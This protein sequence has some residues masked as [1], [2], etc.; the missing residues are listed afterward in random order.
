MTTSSR[1]TAA[2]SPILGW[3][4][5]SSPW[6]SSSGGTSS[7]R[8]PNHEGLFKKYFDWFGPGLEAE[9][10]RYRDEAIR[11]HGTLRLSG[12]KTKLRVP[13]DLVELYVA[14]QA[15][16]DLR[17]HG[18]AGFADSRDVKE[19]LEREGLGREGPLMEAFRLAAGVGRRG[20]VILGEPG[21]GKTT[22]LKRLLLRC[23]QE[24]PESLGLPP[25][26]VPVLLPLRGLEDPDKETVDSFIERH[27]NA[28]IGLSSDFGRRLL[29]RGTLLLLFDGLDEVANP[30]RREKV[31]RWV[32][33]VLSAHPSCS[34]VV[35]C[36]F[37]GYGEQGHGRAEVRL[38]A[39]FLE[40]HIQPLRGDQTEQFI[41]TWYRLV[42]SGLDPD[43]AVVV[44]LAEKRAGSNHPSPEVRE[45][46]G[47]HWR[48]DGAMT[49]KG[50]V[51]AFPE[52][53]PEG[54]GAGALG[55]PE[56][57]P[58]AATGGGSGLA[59][60]DG[61]RRVGRRQAAN[62]GG[63][64]VRVPCRHD[65][66]KVRRRPGCNRLVPQEQRR[67]DASGWPEETQRVGTARHA[68]QRV[69]VL[70]RLVRAVRCNLGLRSAWSRLGLVSGDAWRLLG[71]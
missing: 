40:L 12:F 11:S 34:P 51:R 27:L 55:Q 31:A 41:R 56:V 1:S 42:E 26:M 28:Q 22:H 33:R 9:L 16:S 32:E 5:A 18:E 46:M 24:G 14:L 45:W 62:G 68:R 21:S 54:P 20:L 43:H 63:V 50:G 6:T 36:R 66:G 29:E 58:G 3:P 35:T 71:P 57:Q 2:S 53:E 17:G 48:Q 19:Q 10:G 39:E 15:T 38:S 52:G 49:E 64:G 37:A 65:G 47:R 70:Q 25:E 59:R 13:I 7:S 67:C 8:S 4:R 30:E 60:G 61:V 69:R 23:L 44:R